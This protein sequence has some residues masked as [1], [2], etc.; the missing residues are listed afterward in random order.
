MRA[1]QRQSGMRTAQRPADR[2]NFEM[3]PYSILM[4]KIIAISTTVKVSFFILFFIFI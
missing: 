2:Q 3:L 1:A 4:R